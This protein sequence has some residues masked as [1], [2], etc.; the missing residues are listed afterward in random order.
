[1]TLVTS[2][3]PYYTCFTAAR[4]RAIFHDCKHA[5]QG[6]VPAAGRTARAAPQAPEQVRCPQAPPASPQ[7]RMGAIV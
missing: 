2:P 1:M 3:L 5:A 6:K 4:K 7:G